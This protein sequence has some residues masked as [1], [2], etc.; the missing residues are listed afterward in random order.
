MSPQTGARKLD[1]HRSGL[2]FLVCPDG[3]G[4]DGQ[5][6]AVLG[7]ELCWPARGWDHH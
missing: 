4:A 6:S 7:P 5:G 2:F 1:E 3:Q